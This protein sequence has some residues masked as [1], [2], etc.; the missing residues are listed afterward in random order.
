MEED[1][2]ERLLREKARKALSQL[3][4]QK[5]SQPGCKG[6]EL[7]KALGKGYAGV[8]KLAETQADQIGLK[9]VVVPDEEAKDDPD[10][11]RYVL[12]SKEPLTDRDAGG[13]LR[14]EE[15]ASLAIAL[16]QLY[17]KGGMDTKKAISS[18]IREKLPA[19]RTDQVIGKLVRLGYIEEDGGYLKVGWRSKVEIDRD[20]LLTSI[21]SRGHVS[22]DPEA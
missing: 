19:W 4:V 13:W 16:S 9:L 7:K 14:M 10:R 1:E 3:L 12:V 15:A 11:A 21:L 6:W 8:M 18:I 5:H 2:E 17:V 20:E 22:R